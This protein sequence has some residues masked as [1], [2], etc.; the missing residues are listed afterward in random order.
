M[1]RENYRPADKMAE[2]V[3]ADEATILQ[4]GAAFYFQV[5]SVNIAPFSGFLCFASR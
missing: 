1:L 3:T 4:V 5:T 2:A